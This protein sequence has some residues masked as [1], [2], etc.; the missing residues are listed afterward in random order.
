VKPAEIYKQL[1]ENF[2]H[3][4]FRLM[5]AVLGTVELRLGGRLA[6]QRIRLEDFD[7]TGAARE[8]TENLIDECRR[9]AGVEVAALFVELP[10]G[11]VKCSL[12]SS[13]PV[14]VCGIAAKFGGGGHTTAA[15]AHLQGPLEKAEKRVI[16]ALAA[17]FAA[18]GRS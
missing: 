5:A 6:T 10:D 16:D 14:D 1:Y 2:S 8:D 15:G 11:R 18:T 4:R 13:G 3:E 12:R 9:I 17:E 7:R